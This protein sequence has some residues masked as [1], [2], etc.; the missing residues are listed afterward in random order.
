MK[1]ESLWDI[2]DGSLTLAHVRR[3]AADVVG[4]GTLAQVRMTHGTP[5][6][7]SFTL[8]AG[9]ELRGEGLIEASSITFAGSI[10]PERWANVGKLA[11]TIDRNITAAEIDGIDIGLASNYG[12]ISLTGDVTFAAGSVYHWQVEPVNLAVDPRLVG[13]NHDLIEVT[14]TVTLDAAA[15]LHIDGLGLPATWVPNQDYEIITAT[16][17]VGGV[18]YV[19]NPGTPSANNPNVQYPTNLKNLAALFNLA[20]DVREEV[21]TTTG[22]DELLFRLVT[23]GPWPPPPPP[24]PPPV[25]P[26]VPDPAPEPTPDPVPDPVPEPTPEPPPPVVPEDECRPGM[27]PGPVQEAIICLQDQDQDQID[28]AMD[29]IVGEIVRLVPPCVI[30]RSLPA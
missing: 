26:P 10:R 1:S 2:Q 4:A 7:A 5:A 24:P 16:S 18:A 13:A 21:N 25:P 30:D 12:A 6:S 14:G 19:T 9:A 15:Q 17:I 11:D 23:T 29:N 20:P 8:G 22:D 27:V 3:A 28:R